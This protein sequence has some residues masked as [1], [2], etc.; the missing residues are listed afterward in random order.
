MKQL[1][2]PKKLLLPIAKFLKKKEMDFKR[3][4]DDLERE[5]PFNNI[6]RTIDMASVDTEASDRV[7]HDRI[8][9]LKREVDK[10]LVRIR[11]ALTKVRLG[12]YGICEG[13]GKM[14]DTDRLSVDPSTTYCVQCES[15]RDKK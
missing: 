13:C 8:V 15:G 12:T 7:N 4:R 10:T 11:K 6:D 3:K 2:I 9:A 1:R 5:D 14:I